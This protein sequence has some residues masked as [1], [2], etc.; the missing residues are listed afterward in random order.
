MTKAERKGVERALAH[1][2][3]LEWMTLRKG[4]DTATF[5]AILELEELLRLDAAARGREK[6]G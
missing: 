4:V 3:P 2:A 6:R 5:A 1:L